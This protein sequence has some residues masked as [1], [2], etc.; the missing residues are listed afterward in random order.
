MALPAQNQGELF[1]DEIRPVDETPLKDESTEN[2]SAKNRIIGRMPEI[3]HVPVTAGHKRAT[4]QTGCETPKRILCAM[5]TQEY[6]SWKNLP[7]A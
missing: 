7:G 6:K 5:G 4:R 3:Y 2:R 1:P